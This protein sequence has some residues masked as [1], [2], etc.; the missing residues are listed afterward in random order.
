MEASDDYVCAN[1]SCGGNTGGT[2]FAAPRWAGFMALVNQQAALL[3]KPPIGFLNP[4]IYQIGTTPARYQSD[5][6]DI[7]TGSNGLY[8]A[9]VG[10]DLVTGWGSPNGLQ[11][12]TDLAGTVPCSP[13]WTWMERKG[14]LT[15]PKVYSA[16]AQ[17]SYEG[18]NYTAAFQN[19]GTVPPANSGPS[20]SGKAWIQSGICNATSAA[21]QVIPAVQTPTHPLSAMF[22]ITGMFVVGGVYAD[23]D[24]NPNPGLDGKGNAYSRTLLLGTSITSPTGAPFTLGQATTYNAVSAVGQTITLPPGSFSSL[25]MLGTGVNGAQTGQ[26]TVTYTDG[27]TT[28]ITQTLSA[29]TQ[30]AIPAPQNESVAL[31]MTYCDTASGGITSGSFNLYEYSWPIDNKKT[32]ASLTLPNNYSNSWNVC[33]LALALVP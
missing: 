29:W 10:Y 15:L 4:T 23:G 9:V 5:F 14:L 17:A 30:Q 28:V 33:V 6:H 27:T 21:T 16:G 24:G 32:V 20:G 8:S 26:F 25:A 12:I 22:N 31:S 18:V 13:A 3:G 19:I 7:A 11:L 1:G 2:S